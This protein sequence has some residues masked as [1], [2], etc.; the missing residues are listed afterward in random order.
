MPLMEHKDNF[1]IFFHEIWDSLKFGE[2]KYGP[3][4][5]KDLEADDFY[6]KIV[7][8]LNN[9]RTKKK[10]RGYLAVAVGYIFLWGLKDKKWK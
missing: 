4:T 8:M 3:D 6:E 5:F 1:K 2:A 7:E 9:Y 10:W